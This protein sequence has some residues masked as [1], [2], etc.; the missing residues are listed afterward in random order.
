MYQ[1][2]CSIK[3]DAKISRPFLAYFKINHLL[4]L[5]INDPCNVLHLTCDNVIPIQL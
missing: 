4:D 1:V 5:E 2:L 3:A